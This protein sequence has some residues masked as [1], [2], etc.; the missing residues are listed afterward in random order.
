MSTVLMVD[1][2]YVC[3]RAFYAT[4][5]LSFDGRGTGVAL[6]VIETIE[7][8]RERFAVDRTALAFD[9]GIGQRRVIYPQYKANRRV[10]QTDEEKLLRA[11][12]IKQLK[13]VP[14]V[15]R[16]L[17]YRNL[18]RQRSYEADDVIASVAKR[19]EADDR[20]IIVSA[21]QDLW[22]LIRANVVC[23]DPRTKKV[24]DR[25]SFVREWGLD[26]ALWSH[27]KSLAGDPS[28]NIE[29]IRGVG[30]KTA[31]KYFVSPGELSEKKRDLINNSIGI[32]N[33]N[34]QLIRLPF[35]G[36]DKFD[37]RDD[38]LTA[39]RRAWV[40]ERLGAGGVRWRR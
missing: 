1:M 5:H 39:E 38:E 23:F 18:L 24:M 8:C 29:G 13:W 27:V 31:V 30:L 32:Y 6:G 2:G 15:F 20:G 28:D 7:L 26:P 25:D 10:S 12:Y 17:G 19:L 11:E 14:A 22:Q 40:M 33:R 16:R 9:Y 35:E 34:L 3:S 4:G 21:D 37:L 36:T